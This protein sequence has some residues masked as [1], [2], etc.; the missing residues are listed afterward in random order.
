[1]AKDD[2]SVNATC[3]CGHKFKIP[4]AGE[5]LETMEFTC[6]GCRKVDSFTP[7]QIASLAAAYDRAVEEVNAKLKAVADG[8]KII[9]YRP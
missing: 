2:V 1:M 4:I 8:S 5:D 7:E 9:K 3:E 6:P